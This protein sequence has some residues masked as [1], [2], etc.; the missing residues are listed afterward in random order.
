[1]NAPPAG[2]ARMLKVLRLTLHGRHHSGIDDCKNIT[3]I[4]VTLLKKKTPMKA[5]GR[6]NDNLK[7]E[8]IAE[9]AGYGP[10]SNNRQRGQGR[11]R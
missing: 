6:L 2:M 11:R 4:V 5:T 7:Y 10:Q 8:N 9:Q 3:Q 1:M